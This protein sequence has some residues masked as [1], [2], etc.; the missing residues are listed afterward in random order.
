MI[1]DFCA[2][3]TLVGRQVLITKDDGNGGEGEYS[4][5]IGIRFLLTNGVNV[6]TSMGFSEESARDKSFAD[7]SAT[8][9]DTLLIKQIND[10]EAQFGKPGDVVP[11]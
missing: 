7:I 2:V 3:R 10:L 8:F 1:P 4:H 5:L 6:E 9:Y 11:R